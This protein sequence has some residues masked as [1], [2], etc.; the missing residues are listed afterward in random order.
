MKTELKLE[1]P[2]KSLEETQ[3]FDEKIDEQFVGY[4][5]EYQF[6]KRLPRIIE[7]IEHGKNGI[8]QKCLL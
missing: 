3:E 4:R 5:Q 1:L 8:Q 6:S 7:D 2:R